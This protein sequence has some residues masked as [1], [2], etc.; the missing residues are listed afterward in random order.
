MV[1]LKDAVLREFGDE[2]AETLDR[3]FAQVEYTVLWCIRLLA[4]DSGITAVIPEGVED[5]VIERTDTAELRQVKTRDE[6][7][8]PWTTAEVLPILCKLYHHRRAYPAAQHQFHFVSDRMADTK[9]PLRKNTFG[10]LFRLKQLLEILH[11]GIPW[12]AEE[13]K[14][15]D[16]LYCAIAPQIIEVMDKEHGETVSYESARTLVHRTWIETDSATL[17]S[18]DAVGALGTAFDE[19]FPGATQY[20]TA[21]IREIYGRLLLMV[22]G[23]IRKKTIA[24]RRTVLAD[25]LG[26]RIPF[27][28]V[29]SGTD[30]SMVAGASLLDKKAVLGGFDLT[31]VP[32]F[33]RQRLLAEATV[34]RLIPMGYSDAL[35]RLITDVIDRQTICRDDVCRKQKM[36]K[37]TGPAIL[38]LLRTEIAMLVKRG[39]L[40]GELVDEQLCLGLAWRETDLCTLWW[41]ALG[42]EG[43]SV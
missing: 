18:P 23:K 10:P 5:V 12:S 27:T 38:N 37:D 39:H 43:N 3:Y 41:H 29:G 1:N 21:Q 7:Q 11:A 28:H 15:F 9:T 20:T 24:E 17:R 31:E 42:Y 32:A 40:P 6:G 25:V 4:S 19:A 30:L 13:E 14:D 2:G 34:R 16:L 8:G 22:L 36:T 26:C 35:E 33:H